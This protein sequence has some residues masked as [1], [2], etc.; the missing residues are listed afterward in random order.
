MEAFL[1]LH[2]KDGQTIVMVTHE[3][4]YADKARRVIS[5]KDGA[6]ISDRTK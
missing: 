4:E 2:H 1:D 5:L 6:V 3:E